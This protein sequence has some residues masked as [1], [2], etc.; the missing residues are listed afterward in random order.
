MQDNALY[1]ETDGNES[2]A[3]DE[4]DESRKSLLISHGKLGGFL[5]ITFLYK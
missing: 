5:T 1:K 3:K 4:T 2:E